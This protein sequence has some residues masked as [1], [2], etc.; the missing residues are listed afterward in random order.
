MIFVI[1]QQLPQVCFISALFEF[2]NEVSIEDYLLSYRE[3]NNLLECWHPDLIGSIEN[4]SQ[5]S[6]VHAIKKIDYCD[7]DDDDAYST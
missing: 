3:T 2:D 7:D 6:S 5:C 4:S 1:I